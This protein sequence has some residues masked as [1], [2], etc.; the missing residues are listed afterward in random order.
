MD[1]D[2]L[3]EKIQ[4]VRDALVAKSRWDDSEP[5][6]ETYRTARE[7]LLAVPDLKRSL[8]VYVRN[9]RDL[10]S[11]WNYLKGEHPELKSYESRRK[12]LWEEFKPLLESVENPDSVDTQKFFP[13]GSDHDAYKHIR[14]I[15]QRATSSLLIID[16]YMDS[17]I[18]VVLSTL[19][20]TPD[21]RFL[22]SKIPND[23]GLEGKKFARQH[24]L[25]LEIRTT[26]DFHDRFILVDGKECYFL[27]ASIK[28]AG[29]KG[30]SIVPLR[31]IPVVKF[32]RQYAEEVWNSATP[33]S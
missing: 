24:A 33:L 31:D 29:A 17:T 32:F 30:F 10:S 13:K 14:E 20:K 16:G 1:G 25:A 12:F 28:D 3:V 4:Q 23:F 27:G 26:R 15:L 5:D 8:P 9:C 18:Y 21:V 11:F 2:E 19:T 22:T 7:E 6:R